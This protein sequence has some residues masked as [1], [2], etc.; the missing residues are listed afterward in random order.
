MTIGT[1]L[2]TVGVLAGAFLFALGVIG[3]TRATPTPQQ[4]AAA[5]TET[6][7][8][9]A[10]ATSS[11]TPTPE[12][13][14]SNLYVE[15]IID[16]SDS[17]TETLA[18]GSVKLAVAKDLLKEH[19]AAFKPETNIGLR[20]YGHRVPYQDEGK[21][22]QDI[23]LVAAPRAGQLE[24]IAAWLG[25]FQ[26]LGMTPLAASLQQAFGDFVFDPAR[27]NSIVMLS[28]GIETCG[29]DPC[30]LVES[31]KARGINFTVHVI[32]LDVDGATRDQLTCVARSG[33]GTYQDARTQQDLGIALG[34]IRSAVVKSEVV[35]PP[36]VD[37]PT[38]APTA[39]TP[40]IFPEYTFGPAQVLLP[41]DVGGGQNPSLVAD[42]AGRIHAIWENHLPNSPATRLYDGVYWSMWDGGA[43]SS[44]QLIPGTN[45]CGESSASSDAAGGL[46]V[47]CSPWVTTD[48]PH[49]NVLL[50]WNGIS[51]LPASVPAP[52]SG[53][54]DYFFV[55]SDEGGGLH[56]GNVNSNNRLDWNGS[57]WSQ[58]EG[59]KGWHPW[60]RSV[61][62]DLDGRLFLALEPQDDANKGIALTSWTPAGWTRPDI[63]AITEASVSI[64][65][66]D[67]AVG[68]NDI[69]HL[70][71]QEFT[72]QPGKNGGPY[73]IGYS[74][75]TEP[76]AWSAPV[77]LV[78]GTLTSASVQLPVV[79]AAPNGSVHV[80]YFCDGLCYAYWDGRMW[81]E[82][83]RLTSNLSDDQAEI[84]AT[85]ESGVFV[86]WRR[87]GGGSVFAVKADPK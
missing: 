6:A 51:W 25:E 1:A 85:R 41:A 38:P 27:I 78:R 65:H 16:A 81:S 37:T 19:V 8:P 67:I 86:V 80:V 74:L 5:A 17:M 23:E 73:A 47:Y 55:A 34:I 60:P 24:T 70:V 53:R 21:S 15:Y 42:G 76:G 62:Y 52:E 68:P 32:G 48:Q 43:W 54:F 84:I 13:G 30:R 58:T 77:Y 7:S 56:A 14:T 26:A 12:L 50:Q 3:P 39:V 46:Y 28:D 82:T 71:W 20:A 35:V 75:T 22:C 33:G 69:R 44:A 63:L 79:A 9:T 18:D 59:E 31:L 4:Q 10:T 64:Q 87:N 40:S 36:G 72:F 2:V 83:Q 57:S 49:R 29:G 66:P 61:G 11:P 45:N